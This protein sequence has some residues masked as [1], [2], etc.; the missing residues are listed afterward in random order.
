MS[1]DLAVRPPE[2]RDRAALARML[3]AQLREHRIATSEA[4]IEAALGGLLDH[5]RRGAALIAVRADAPIGFAA[6]SFV[7]TLEHGG[8]AAWLEELYVVPEER[9]AGVGTA[10]LRAALAE[11]AAAGARAVD[12]EVDRGHARAAHLYE[13]ESFRRHDRERWVRDL[14]PAEQRRSAPAPPGRVEGRCFCGSIRF[15]I[16]AP[17]LEVLHCHCSICRRTSGAPV[18]TWAVF[19]VA[20]FGL[21]A[22]EPRA[23]LSSAEAQRTFC[24]RCGSPLTFRQKNRPDTIDVTVAT[25]DHPEAIAP[26]G[27]I[28][29]ESRLPWLEL[30]DDLPRRARE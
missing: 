10:L 19:P 15:A 25:L 16:A 24:G 21:V 23:L 17:P 11:A 30:A 5:P 7:W 8:K 28:W 26:T 27:H 4:E 12:L 20:A 22:G 13:R 29:T 1:T 9:G 2:D 6:L 14:A 3:V 18:V